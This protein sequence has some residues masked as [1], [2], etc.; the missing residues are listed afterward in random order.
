MSDF[1][2]CVTLACKIAMFTINECFRS[3]NT[4]NDVIIKRFDENFNAKNDSR[5][6]LTPGHVIFTTNNTKIHTCDARPYDFST[7]PS[8]TDSDELLAA[9]SDVLDIFFDIE[10]A[11]TRMFI[12]LVNGDV[13]IFEYRILLFEWA[14]I[15]YF[16]VNIVS[17]NSNNN[18]HNTI[19]HV[20]ISRYQNTI[21]WAEK[22]NT[23]DSCY[24]LNK[25]EISLNGVREITQSAVGIPQ[26]LLKNCTKFELV[27]IRDNICVIPYLPNNV[28]L[29][30]IISARSHIWLFHIDGK[31]LYRGV[32][33]D[34]PTD[35]ISL[36]TKTIGLWNDTGAVK[37]CKLLNSTKSYA[38]I[39]HNKL[40]LSIAP[41][42]EISKRVS[43]NINIKNV[44]E[45]YIMHNTLFSFYDDPL[46]LHIYNINNEQLIQTLDMNEYNL[47]KG[48]WFNS[49]IIPSL[50]FYTDN[51]V[52][53]ISYKP[54][55]SLLI[56]DPASVIH[57]INFLKQ[58]HF[59]IF[60]LLK[61]LVQQKFQSTNLK[62]FPLVTDSLQ[63]E[64][65][66]LAVLQSCREKGV[67]SND[68][69]LKEIVSLIFSEK[70]SN[71]NATRL[72]E[73]LDPLVECFI[74][75]EKNR[76]SQCQVV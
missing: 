41:N 36:C 65:L 19:I 27:E 62:S 6:W 66:F 32:I 61:D 14:R 76:I 24:S 16:N 13:Q 4:F 23:S 17:P 69:P 53:K 71:F 42:G 50:G 59:A 37:V 18:H 64:A 26:K 31:L 54:H 5:L 22:A 28:N 46:A 43:L 58:E 10:S 55:S 40:L 2:L 73:L 39:L 11:S 35:F 20:L 21:Y 75:F 52:F 70:R 33:G 56:S 44:K 1:C 51:A 68:F 60:L 9:V 57:L 47:I 7:S 49:S 15:G 67:K 12:V 74:K 45:C 8:E 63:S 48:M 25:R 3:S 29:Y 34:S 72:K 38:Y 30:I